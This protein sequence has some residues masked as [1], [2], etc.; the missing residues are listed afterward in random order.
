MHRL[1][2]PLLALG[3]AAASSAH[4][5]EIACRFERGVPVVAAMV[6]G[7]PGDFIL[8][9]GAPR[10]LLHETKAQAAGIAETDLIVGASIAGLKIEGL[11]I[12]VADLD[13][14]GWNL[15][16]PLGGVIGADALKGY[17]VDVSY[18]PC[19]I[20]LSLPGAAPAFRGHALPL[21]WDEGRPVVEAAVADE[22]REARGRFV[23]A[24]G[25]N[26]PLRLASDLAEVAGVADP[27]ELGPDGVWLARLPR[28]EFAGATGQD[29]AAGLMPPQGDIAGVLGGPVLSHF[30]LR[31]DFPAG[32]L[33][34]QPAR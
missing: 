26:A 22:A 31:F 19:R 6:A 14:R 23:V 2:L 10:T 33:T 20:R 30:R 11:S 27:K 24:T 5:G 3:L 1:S 4:A 8:D 13:V 29:V 34:V 17:V 7:L 15:T 32:R 16:T 28:V 9:T 12:G 21:I 25:A 18:S